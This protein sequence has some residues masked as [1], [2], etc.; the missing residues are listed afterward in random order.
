MK[1]GCGV[2]GGWKWKWY[3][4][5]KDFDELVVGLVIGWLEGVIR[6]EGNGVCEIRP[7]V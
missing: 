6:E 7:N 3:A 1:H 5:W 4:G 2:R